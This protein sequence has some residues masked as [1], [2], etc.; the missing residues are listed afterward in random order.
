MVRLVYVEVFS[1][2]DDTIARE[3]RVKRWRRE[4]KAALIEKTNPQWH[5]LAE[6]YGFEPL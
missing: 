2:A 1:R 3:K 5:D 4:K 6:V